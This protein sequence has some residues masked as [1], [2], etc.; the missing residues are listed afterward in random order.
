MPHPGWVSVCVGYTVWGP[1][2]ALRSLTGRQSRRKARRRARRF[3][4]RLRAAR[5]TGGI[6]AFIAMAADALR[7]EPWERAGLGL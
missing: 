1:R 3:G 7:L 5:E 6:P 2:Y 4:Q